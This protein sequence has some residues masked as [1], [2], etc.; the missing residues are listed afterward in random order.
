MSDY[1]SG[2]V[3]FA[4][5]G[6]GTDFNKLID[7]LVKVEQTRVTRLEN[8]KQEW[9]DKV[10]AFKE[11]NTKMLALKSSL[12]GM[13]TLNE[14]LVKSVASTST[15]ELTATA[16]SSAQEATH[17]VIINQLAQNAVLTNQ[18][19]YLATNEVIASGAGTVFEYSYQG[20]AHSLS[21]P[22]GTTLDGLVNLINNDPDKGNVK[23]SLISD[24][25]E[26]FLQL[27][28]MDLGSSSTLTINAATTVPGFSSADWDVTQAN[29]NAQVRI[30]GWPVGDW[31]SVPSNTIKNVVEGLTLNLKGA[32]PGE[33]I[34][35]TVDTDQEAVKENVRTFVKQ[36]NEVRSYILSLTKY[37]KVKEEGSLLTGNYGVD[38]ISQKLKNAAAERGVGF[39]FYDLTGAAPS[40]DKYS[41]LSQLGILTDADDSSPTNG[42]LVLDEEKLTEALKDDTDAVAK[43]FAVKNEGAVYNTNDFVYKS[44]I[45]GIT[46]PGAYNVKYT[47][48]G[49]GNIT[50]AFINGHAA[51]IDNTTH[52]IM[53]LSN[54][55]LVGDRLVEQN[56]EAGIVLEVLNLAAGTYPASGTNDDDYPKILLKQGKTGEMSDLLKDLTNEN[57]GPLHI[58]E[59][60]YEDIMDMI[61]KKIEYE[62]NRI[63]KMERTMRLKFARLDALLGDYSGKTAQLNAQIAQLNKS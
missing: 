58:L 26:V 34:T 57:T 36:V 45:E 40:G 44:F 4:G 25:S 20:T 55:V 3:N 23:A 27:R 31:I 8:W 38:I 48:D 9:Q 6:N 62:E 11:L 61:D 52:Q 15:E 59:D 56:N 14:F 5:L 17:S 16:D 51:S 50:S 32:A 18:N 42:L 53:G 46:K 13:D 21:I 10:D 1:T 22:A 7:G 39:F 60:N 41:S 2:Q 28:G 37:D 35:L 29:Q 19:G 63:T 24:G 47:V 54:K 49:S 33:T 43:L 30:D 12:D